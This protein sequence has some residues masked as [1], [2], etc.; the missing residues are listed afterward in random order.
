M[1]MTLVSLSFQTSVVQFPKPTLQMSLGSDL[2]SSCSRLDFIAIS[3]CLI[4]HIFPVSYREA[5][6]RLWLLSCVSPQSC[7]SDDNKT[8]SSLR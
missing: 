6:L 7:G 1:S 3:V 5:E 8:N 4:S 2:L